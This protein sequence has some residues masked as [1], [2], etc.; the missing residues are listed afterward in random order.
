MLNPARGYCRWP[1][2]SKWRNSRSTSQGGDRRRGG[3]GFGLFG[4]RQA[5]RLSRGLLPVEFLKRDFQFVQRVV[6]RLVHARA[7]NWLGR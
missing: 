2:T 3:S 5:G 4:W 1:S 7:L 6:A